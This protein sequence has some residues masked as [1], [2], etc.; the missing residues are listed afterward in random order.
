MKR[1][2]ARRLG[3]AMVGLF[4]LATALRPVT[5]Q[6]ELCRWELVGTGYELSITPMPAMTGVAAV[7]GGLVLKNDGRVYKYSP[8]IAAYQPVPGLSGITT[9]DGGTAIKA[10]GTVWFG[11]VWS[12]LSTAPAVLQTLDSAGQVIALSNVVSVALGRGYR[13]HILAVKADGT[14]WA[15]GDNAD[16]QLGDGTTTNRSLAVQ[17]KLQNGTPLSNV[18][19][20]FAFS[21]DSFTGHSYAIKSDDTVWAW[22]KGPFGDGSPATA[23]RLNPVQVPNL[24]GIGVRE[25]CLG[26]YARKA[27]GKVLTWG[28]VN[29]L[30]FMGTGDLVAHLTPV[31][32][33]QAGGA[34]LSNVI[35]LAACWVEG[36]ML[37]TPPVGALKAD[38]TVWVWGP[39]RGNYAQEIGWVYGTSTGQYAVPAV[40]LSDVL[41]V[42]AGVVLR[43]DLVAIEAGAATVSVPEGGT[44]TVPVRLGAAPALVVTVTAVRT[45]G[46]TNITVQSGASLTF[47]PANWD[48]WQ[49]V[50]L[51]AAVD[52][53]AIAGRATISLAAA[54]FPA[55]C[56]VEAV[57]VD[58]DA[59]ADIA[60]WA[61]GDNARGQLGDGTTIE[62]RAPVRSGYGGATTVACGSDHSMARGS[63]G[64]VWTWGFNGIGQLGDSTK[65]DHINPAQVLSLANV[66]NTAAFDSY[67]VVVKTD[68]TVWGWGAFTYR[69]YEPGATVGYQTIPTLVPGPANISAVAAGRVHGMALNRDGRV[70]TWGNSEH[71]QF[72]NGGKYGSPGYVPALSNVKAIAAG[73]H[74]AVVLKADGSVWAWGGNECGELGDGSTIERLSPVQTLGLS[75][76]TAIAAGSTAL[77]IDRLWGVSHTLALKNDGTVWAWGNNS[78]GELGDGTVNNRTTPVRV[79]G[80]SN[81]TAIAAGG[82]HSVAR[83]SD[84]RVWTWGLNGN[85]QLGD[86]TTT[87][88]LTPMPVFG[89]ITA[90]AAGARHTLAVGA[91]GATAPVTADDAYSTPANTMLSVAAPGLLANDTGV[92]LKANQIGDPAHGVLIFNA[93][94][95]FV[96]VPTYNFSGHDSFTYKASSGPVQGN[97]AVV[98]L[99]VVAPD[100]HPP[101][102]TA[103]ASATPNPVTLPAGTTVSVAA[104]DPDT[105]TLSYAWS[106]VAGT[107]SAF[108]AAPAAAS[109]G[110]TFSGPGVYSLQ[111]TVSD[112]HGGSVSSSVTVTAN[113]NFDI[114]ADINHD[115][116]VNALDSQIV[117]KNFGSST[118]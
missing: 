57:E 103:A 72:G 33:V 81:V 113:L 74:H 47:T 99:T 64:T 15:K 75:N 56:T 85:G 29:A 19:A 118:K 58:K 8:A 109:S 60:V 112:G 3:L 42:G 105:N 45:S 107:G 44:A 54:G 52:A 68:G 51:A 39:W 32:V 21:D 61:W 12:G 31:P 101:T 53:D 67:S 35:S 26:M 6:A 63:D 114:R 100:N 9:L 73:M 93:D 13:N 2:V 115:G 55:F 87:S 10:D 78:D 36:M 5:V 16:G 90:I 34:A 80:L 77:N 89:G 88:R 46:D 25:I 71:G 59:L 22:G 48:V 17:V 62:R 30:G 96:Y 95:S 116:V 49:K 20:V 117:I 1:T 91:S 104:S 43:R 66:T 92:A 84:G 50:T 108:F 102:I 38:G 70:W 41:A 86:G 79:S 40:G 94:G 65:T 76:V 18:V 83:T 111:V 37:S 24:S 14:V 7:N 4:T 69:N 106:Q 23:I 110:V 97:L 98:Q 27:D 28:A 11:D 82:S